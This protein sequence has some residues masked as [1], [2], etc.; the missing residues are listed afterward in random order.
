MHTVFDEANAERL[1]LVDILRWRA[2]H[3][4]Q[5]EAYTFLLDGETKRVQ[6]TYA[7]LDHQARRIAALLQDRVS[8]GE[9]VLLLYQPGL[10]YVAAV[11]GC[12]Y[13]GVVAVPAYPPHQDRSLM[14]IQTILRDAQATTVLATSTMLS[15]MSYPWGKPKGYVKD[16]YVKDGYN[17]EEYNQESYVQ[18][19]Q[20][21]TTDTMDSQAVAAYREL[22]VDPEALALLQ[23]TS[24]STSSPK[25][26]MLTHANLMQ[27]AVH[28]QEGL[29]LT[30][31]DRG[32]SW[33]PPYHDMGLMAGILQALY[34][35]YPTVLMAP[36]AFVQ[37]PLRWLQAISSFRA[38]FSGGPNFAFDL[39][40]KYATP[41]AIAAL[42]LSSWTLAFNG[43]EPVRAE[44]LQRFAEMF[45]P[46]GFRPE[47]FYPCYGM[48][49][50]TL[51]VSGGRKDELPKIR[52]FGGDAIENGYAVEVT[53]GQEPSRLLVG[54][55]YVRQGQEVAIV[56]P[57][58]HTRCGPGTI[59][60][61]WVRGPN[62]ALGYWGKVE[63][64]AETF[65]AFLQGGDEGP[66]LRTGDLGFCVDDELFIAGRLKDLIIIRG[67]NLY[68]Q[69]IERVA[70]MSHPLLR[71][72]CCAAF[73]V[74]GQDTEQLVIV[75]E[76]I[77]QWDDNDVRGKEAVQA[78]CQAVMSEFGVEVAAIELLRAGTISKTTSG[79]I[80]RRACRSRFLAGELDTVYSFRHIPPS[81]SGDAEVV[82]CAAP[83]TGSLPCTTPSKLQEIVNW[84]VKHIAERA[85]MD[86]HAVDIHVPFVA[87]GLNSLEAIGLSNELEQWLG[88]SL[89]PT[90]IY[91]YPSIDALARSLEETT[92][93][94]DRRDSPLRLSERL[95][96]SPQ[97]IN[98]AP[99]V[100]PLSHN[101][102]ALWFHS[103]LAPESVAYNVLYAVRIR[104]GLDVVALRRVLEVLASCYPIL[105]STYTL[106]SDEP[107][108]QT[109]KNQSL[110]QE[111]DASSASLD[112][113]KVLFHEESNRPI[114]L[115]MGPV[116]RLQLYRRADDDY[117][118]GFIL[119]HIVVDFWALDILIEELQYLY[120]I[121]KTDLDSLPPDRNEELE[122][123][124]PQSLREPRFQHAD[125]VR[126][127]QSMLQSQEG[128]YHWQYWQHALAGDLPILHL[129]TDRPRPPVQ[130]YNG[131][132]HNFSL[133]TDLEQ[134]L[135]ALASEN[136]VTLFTLMLTVYQVLL[137]RYSDQDD[138]LVGVPAL[139]RTHSE[140][141]RVIGSLTNPVVVRARF[142][143]HSTFKELLYQTE[144]GVLSALE[145]QDFPFSLLV[146][147]L[148]PARDPS[149]SPIYQ[150]LFI[151]NR[152]RPFDATPVLS[153]KPF[154]YGQQG[155]LVDL[156]L[157][158]FETEGRLSANLSYNIDL[159]DAST[160]SRMAEHFLTLLTGI[161][162]NPDQRLWEIPL[163]PEY[164]RQTVLI[165]WN[166]TSGGV[167]S[168]QC[169]Y[170][171]DLCLHQLFEQQVERTPAAVALIF[172]DR[173]NVGSGLAPDSCACPGFTSHVTYH[174][175]NAQ[176]NQL[177]HYLRERGIGPDVLVGVC[178]ERSLSLVVAL[179]AV[180]KAGGAYVPL[181]PRLPQE[182]LNFLLEDAQ[183]P[184]VLTQAHL[185]DL[186]GLA[187]DDKLLPTV[188]LICLGLDT[189]TEAVGTRSDS[190]LPLSAC[191]CPMATTKHESR[192][193]PPCPVQ[194]DNLAYVIYTSGSTGQPK[195]VQIPHHAVINF[196]AAM[197][198]QP[199]LE[200]SDTLLAVTSVSFDIAGLELFLPLLASARIVMA[201]REVAMDGEQLAHA[202]YEHGTTVM[203]ATPSTWR[204]LLDAQWQAQ[205]NMKVLCGGEAFPRDLARQ[206]LN[207]GVEVW[208]LYGPTETTIWSTLHPVASVDNPLPI[209]R[210]IANTQIYLLDRN[211]QP[212][213]IGVAGEL[214]IGGEGLA[215]G[216]C[217]RPALTAERFIPNPFAYLFVETGRA[218]VPAGTR[219]Y[220]TGDL[221]RYRTDGAI[222]YLGRIDSQVKLRGFRI[223]L[224]EIEATLQAHPAVREAV[225]VLHEDSDPT[226]IRKFLLAYVV[227]R[228]GESLTSETEPRE[229]TIEAGLAPTLQEYLH[230][231][232][233]DYMLPSHLVFLETMPLTP[234]GKVDR[235]ALPIPDWTR[236]DRDDA[237]VQA[238]TPIEEV[239]ATIWATVLGRE[240]VSMHDNFFEVGGHSLLVTQLIA[241]IRAILGVEIPLRAVF[242]SSTVA[243]LALLVEQAMRKGEK[244]QVPPL[245]PATSPLGGME[246]PEEIPLSLAQQRLWFLDQLEPGNTAYLIPSVHRL[247]GMLD[248]HCFERSLQELLDRHESLRTTFAAHAGN[249]VQV[250]HEACSPALSVIDL[251][252]LMPEGQEEEMRRLARQEAAY[253]CDL[254]RGPLLRTSLLR[255]AREEHVLLLTL[256]HIITDG[257]SMGVLVRELSTLYRAF[258][259]G[260]PSPL[261]PLPIQY[262]DYT[263]WQRQWLQGQVLEVQM[264]YWQK[265][266]AEVSSLAFPSDYPRPTVQTY[267]GATQ[268][269]ICSPELS[270]QVLAFSRREKV[271]LFMTLLAAFQVLLA[272]YTG[273]SDICVG[274]PIANRRQAE[275]E[276]VIGFFV[277]TLVLR[278][279]LSGNPTFE[280]VLR[281]VRE[282]CLGAYVHQDIPFEKVV[283]ELHPERFLSHSPLFNVMVVMENFPYKQPEELSIEPLAM[284]NE[285]SKVDL[286]L[287]LVETE[288]GLSCAMSYN[289]DLFTAETISRLLNH[290]QTL[291]QGLV[292]SPQ[293]PIWDVPLLT[294]DER[295]QLLVAW[296]A[297][298]T[299][300]QESLCIH[301]LFEQQVERMPDA[302]AVIF[303]EAATTYRELDTRANQ[304]AHYLR[305]CGVGP[306]VLVGVCLERSLE[307][308][309]ALLGILKAGGAYVPLDPTYPQARL[310]FMMQDSQIRLLLTQSHLQAQLPVGSLPIF[311]LDSSQSS[312]ALCPRTRLESLVQPDNS[313]YVIYTSGSTGT[314]KGVITPH[315]GVV[316]YL[317]SLITTYPLDGG[318]VLQLPSIS[319][320]PSIRDIIGPLVS[321]ASTILLSPS[322]AKD[323]LAIV[324]K[325]SIYAITSLL[326]VVPSLL[327]E[328]QRVM[329]ETHISCPT[330]HTILANGET[331]H[332]SDFREVQA[333]INEQAVFVN[334]YGPTECPMVSSCYTVSNPAHETR[335]HLPIGR[336]L[337][338][339][340]MYILDTYG[341]PVPVGVTGELYIGGKLLS[342]GYLGQP[343]LTAER[344]L[345]NPFVQAGPWAG[346]QGGE[347]LYKTGDLARYRA[348][349]NIEWL[350]RL[351]QQVK[352]RGYRIELGEIES[353]LQRH[354]AVHEAIV[355]AHAAHTGAKQLVAYVARSKQEE[356]KSSDLRKYLQAKLPDY[357]VPSLFV[358]L[359]TLPLLPNGKVDRHALPVPHDLSSEHTGDLLFVEPRTQSEE[360]L[361]QIWMRVLG[362]SQVSIHANFFA[363]GGHSLLAT[364]VVS[365]I[366]QAIQIEFPLRTL[367]AA[368]TIAELAPHIEASIRG[369]TT[370][371]ARP[372]PALAAHGVSDECALSFAQERLWFLYQLEPHSSFYT[373]PYVL[374]PV[375]SLSLQALERSLATLVQRHEI[376][377]TTFTVLRDQP[378]QVIAPRLAIHTPLIDLSDL[379]SKEQKHQIHVL[380]Q[381]EKQRPF[382]LA[383][384]PLLRSHIL[385][386]D[387]QDHILVFMMHHIISD[388]WSTGILAREL[389]VLYQTYVGVV[390][391]ADPGRCSS[392]MS[393]SPLPNLPIQY[394]DYALWQRQWLQGEVLETQLDYW[395]QQLK[396]APEILN[397]PT[398]RPR[399]AV[400]SYK[401][402]TQVAVLPPSLHQALVALGQREGTTL[403]MTL[404]AAYQVL[405]MRYSGQCDILIGTPIANRTR[406]ELENLIGFLVNT[407]VM[408]IDLSGNPPFRH[409][410]ARV[411]EV[412]LGGFAHQDLPFE[413]LVDALQVERKPSFS[414]LFQAFFAL[415]NAPAAEIIW[416]GLSF[417]PV[418]LVHTT[419]RFDLALEMR[420]TE[421]GLRATVEYV[422]DLFDG[423]TI[424]RF[425]AHWQ[426]LLEGIVADPDQPIEHLPLLTE[427]EREH[428]RSLW[429]CTKIP[430]SGTE[431]SAPQA[432]CL[433]ELFDSK[434]HVFPMLS[435]LLSKIC[436]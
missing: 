416:P 205:S 332:L 65:Q 303:E 123:R 290:W 21:I 255:L 424:Q 31:Q 329:A 186:M 177:A 347:L 224:G 171:Q 372:L 295:E 397:L 169:D 351:D 247:H 429:A 291:L 228:V 343:A 243:G 364:Q 101:Q 136:Q 66:F 75:Q 277:N 335:E 422:S 352:I 103:R 18:K 28:L 44:T 257:W 11:F 6:M 173:G 248:V 409:L 27:N 321:G 105:T 108:Q 4:P 342:R 81:Q 383:T 252:G 330:L 86:A 354:P 428:I 74:E 7:D 118:L 419:A 316:N 80:Q 413:K 302:I 163:L 359:D 48:A 385:R 216:Y 245:V 100:N 412:A 22:Y 417:L 402:S 217:R 399:P 93:T 76:V 408:R 197:S 5:R 310:A 71:Q 430:V 353:V 375:G 116:F 350:G 377:R 192:D 278:T 225:V 34:T 314:P 115:T 393:S 420:V 60:E 106:Q 396:G 369:G 25:G 182:R 318:R 146:E 168:G 199:G 148:Q 233:P 287:Y 294:D 149:F 202:L 305:S 384:G 235:K 200:A 349:G 158:M 293:I 87:F 135:R 122:R 172:D 69:D 83:R 49:E 184:V 371:P 30:S 306:E 36:A 170:L 234:N 280:Q 114:D 324:K 121:E 14:R 323:P 266:L 309:M 209:G 387:M 120:L 67:R 193:N 188:E 128:E 328:L 204:I 415:Q 344:F 104:S 322:E 275:I 3:S 160:I 432:T 94:N 137:H 96:V 99:L 264:L 12:F 298:Q 401:G 40:V 10:E 326:S 133:S 301:Q 175:L 51:F 285:T 299:D 140:L 220:R 434:P 304:L 405:L 127:Q 88:R 253:P 250:I 262:A 165:E 433:H 336:P 89:A 259:S 325:I 50:T 72:G 341:H 212:V 376:L 406:V 143:H 57:Q 64:T 272:R 8:M 320:E 340:K 180:L 363:L 400:Q 382:D 241:Q 77:R 189:S 360:L 271:T 95:S 260:Q 390:P 47:M 156:S 251:Q 178:M 190:G 289:T 15:P 398:D 208:N 365:H 273:Q 55:G 1:T 246:R 181:D 423:A 312:L 112:D 319:F 355:L 84:L 292:D 191:A 403:F 90:L 53:G 394:R 46:C 379:D 130:T 152:P 395:L 79:K 346:P 229:A 117:I 164:E 300:D 176:A 41:E 265:Q 214:Y 91:E 92:E 231:Q 144:R 427:G 132:L 435:L 62:V 381:L 421:E 218:P 227:A 279:D 203:Q 159:F 362:C 151:W 24:G 82:P 269:L 154:A 126:W 201:S 411:R 198:R 358:M 270:E 282:V 378:V 54:C 261:A 195:G 368:P 311:C 339:R 374:H 386:L 223:E 221:A 39:C 297:T 134:R 213:P 388:G 26:V 155:V 410:L 286:T 238:R 150:T 141:E 380:V 52:A 73:A 35:G 263:L 9:R 16:G 370:A 236:Q 187:L 281:R 98:H 356:A 13:A 111:I 59:G 32:L 206:L 338:N 407:L 219:L 230:Q 102:R 124:E 17:Q 20:W 109:Q 239:L 284:Q 145:H 418:N 142:G 37:R 157:M 317:S 431:G 237:V 254:V 249:V 161:V 404:L 333:L 43:A 131:A 244:Q 42:D 19:L 274:S 276:G 210:P 211:L 215:R 138:I 85:H 174:E 129:P 296:N 162:N 426:V 97:G 185:R 166:A 307:M 2:Q 256:H 23:Y 373:L 425:L 391:C 242:E 78:I 207:L 331:L 194:P 107:V 436:L 33:V 110:L 113:L 414:P 232:L 63:E 56:D 357:M 179:L 308:V 337:S 288:Q 345:P 258:V 348:D 125:Y 38:T 389:S 313:A 147:R 139:G 315:R 29:S 196:L 68:P 226:G 119:Q 361:A 61:I 366:R 367:F 327:R 45:A 283:E 153:L 183:V 58:T 167:A 222:E 240:K 267:R 268:A 334:Q 70:E 392:E